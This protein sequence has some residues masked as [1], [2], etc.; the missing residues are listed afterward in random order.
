MYCLARLH[1]RR[2]RF[3]QAGTGTR[4]AL[5]TLVG[6]A[7]FPTQVIQRTR[8]ACDRHVGAGSVA[9]R[10]ETEAGVAD[11][12]S[13]HRPDTYGEQLWNY[14]ARSYPE[15]MERHYPAADR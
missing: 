6:D 2:K 13:D 9:Q 4:C 10:A 5:T 1:R 7:E 14:F 15:L 3:A 11:M 12:A 8:A